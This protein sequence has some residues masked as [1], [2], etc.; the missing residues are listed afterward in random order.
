MSQYPP[1]PVQ[2]PIDYAAPQIPMPPR[3]PTS[4]TVLAIIGIIF[5]ALGVLCTPLGLIPYFMDFGQPNPVIDAIKENKFAFFW[6]IGS[7]I[8]GILL[9]V[10]LLAGSIGSLKLAP[11]AR[12][13][14]LAYAA[15]AV[16]MSLAGTVISV[17]VIT[18][19]VTK[20]FENMQGGGGPFAAMGGMIGAIVGAVLMLI[21]PICILFFYNTANVKDAFANPPETVI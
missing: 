14:M 13:A 20:A 6:T 1:P 18:P 17:T 2:P 19:L 12:S 3:R 9:A 5:G 21:Y 10:I 15:M 4:V 7:S 16:V 8:L 11:W